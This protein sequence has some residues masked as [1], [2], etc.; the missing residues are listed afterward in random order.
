M[1]APFGMAGVAPRFSLA[2]MVKIS[3]RRLASSRHLVSV[4]LWRTSSASDSRPFNV[5]ISIFNSAM[6]R[7]AVA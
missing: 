6:D 3:P 4:P 1:S 5:S 7:A 2:T